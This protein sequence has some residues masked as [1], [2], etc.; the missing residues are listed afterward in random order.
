MPNKLPELYLYRLT[1]GAKQPSRWHIKSRY[2]VPPAV[3]SL[4][5]P[6][7]V[8]VN[9]RPPSISGPFPVG[10][11][12]KLTTDRGTWS[13][14]TPITLY[15]YQWFRFRVLQPLEI[16]PIISQ[17]TASY[18]STSD[19]VGFKIF[20]QVVATN[21]GGASAPAFSN[22]I[23][24][25]MPPSDQNLDDD[26]LLAID[27]STA[28]TNVSFSMNDDDRD[29][30]KSGVTVM[31]GFT[32][33]TASPS[34]V[35][36]N[37]TLGFFSTYPTPT[38]TV[39][40]QG[41]SVQGTTMTPLGAPGENSITLSVGGTVLA[42]NVPVFV[43]LIGCKM[44][45]SM[46]ASSITVQTDKDILPSS[47]VSSG[48]ISNSHTAKALVITCIDFRLVDEAL[49]Y[50]TSM[51]L[52]NEYDEMIVAGACLGYNTSC[53]KVKLPSVYNPLNSALNPTLWTDCVDDHISISSALHKFSQLIVIDHLG[54]G[55]YNGQYGGTKTNPLLIYDELKYHVEQLNAFRNTIN[56]KYQ[57]PPYSITSVISLMSLDGSVDVNPTHW[58]VPVNNISFNLKKYDVVT[59]GQESPTSNLPYLP[60][61]TTTMMVTTTTP[62]SYEF[63]NSTGGN[64]SINKGATNWII[65]N[66]ISGTE[67]PNGGIVYNLRVVGTKAYIILTM[68][69]NGDDSVKFTF[70]QGVYT[71]QS[72]WS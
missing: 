68:T 39:S 44:G 69:A 58:D 28:V 60:I 9:V 61:P 18:I 4:L 20:C 15:T 52:L 13:S 53:N 24:V 48:I 50:L 42:A 30:Y 66:S 40:V 65:Q 55:A 35:K 7:P 70:S 56:T 51:A 17:T 1:P 41:A 67:V 36:L 10:V 19:D 59:I 27:E 8:P 54:C 46:S 32:P 31:F 43:T 49:A 6:P 16:E 29:D 33:T 12:I 71:A 23:S 21:A 47:P 26:E 2:P 57:N 38:C 63:T 25:S 37:Y 72:G 5:A 3:P 14:N 64:V 11:G 34:S 45:S 22:V 62:L